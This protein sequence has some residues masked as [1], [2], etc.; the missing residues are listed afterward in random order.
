[1]FFGIDLNQIFTFPFK[2][3]EAR[4]YFLIGCFISLA[5]FIIPVFPYFV[6]FGYAIRIVKQIMNNEPPRMVAWD[7]WD[8]MFR[9]GVKIFGIR[10]IYSIP[11]IVLAVPLFISMIG[12]TIFLGNASSSEL[13]ALIPISMLIFF[14][15]MCVLIPISLTLAVIIPA[16][17]MYVVE[18]D[19][20]AAGFR[21]KAWW[22]IF[23][24]N[25]SGFI[26]AFMVYYL[27]AMAF[28]F[29][30]QV[31]GATL[32]F[33]CLMPFLLPAMTMYLSLIMY[34]TI[35]QAYKVGKEKLAQLETAPVAL[36]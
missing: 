18:N 30:I 11:I 2:D 17:E 25:I 28:G 1:M 32:I 31:I 20:F 22:P 9:D 23:R 15:I 34:T 4:R 5:A 14:G 27:S 33:A 3:A 13:D 19:E 8:L 36:N 10:M 21:I 16:A 7:D 26:A 24:A 12:M 29:A 6:L 35:A